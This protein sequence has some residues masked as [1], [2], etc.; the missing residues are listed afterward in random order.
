MGT[1]SRYLIIAIVT[2]LVLIALLAFR[3]AGHAADE[4]VKPYITYRSLLY[5]CGEID[6][7]QAE[8]GAW[9]TS[10]LMLKTFR[11]Y[12][13][14]DPGVTDQWG[15]EYVLL[16]YDESRGYGAVLS[17]G[18]DGQLGGQGLD[19]DLEVRF[20]VDDNAKWNEHVGSGLP[21][22]GFK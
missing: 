22:S 12:G 9:P 13:W 11:G 7:H 20:P 18:R 2:L 1:Y 3:Y 8:S 4:Q 15:R 6:S 5:I 17:Y 19:A 10:L 14:D 21:R 16:T